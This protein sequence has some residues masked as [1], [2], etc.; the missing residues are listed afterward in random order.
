VILI[1]A[2]CFSLKQNKIGWRKEATHLVVVTTDASFH[3]A[4]DGKLAAILEANDMNCHLA[5]AK[6][7][8]SQLLCKCFSTVI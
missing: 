8:Y 2:L 1:S 4:L 3:M 7:V 5:A 6:V